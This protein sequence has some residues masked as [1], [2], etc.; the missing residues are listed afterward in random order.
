MAVCCTL[1]LFIEILLTRVV[2]AGERE[3]VAVFAQR[4]EIGVI[5]AAA[6]KAD[7]TALAGK[8]GWMYFTPELR[9]IS[10][11]KFWGPEAVAV[12]RASKREYADPFQAITDFHSQL[13]QVGIEL[14]LVPVPL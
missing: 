8:H 2:T 11:G 1:T 7:R 14:L 13:K 3:S 12:S 9:A 10:V 5:A 4:Q 6:E